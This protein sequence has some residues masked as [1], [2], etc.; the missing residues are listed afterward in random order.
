MRPLSLLS[1]PVHN[2]RVKRHWFRRVRSLQ[3]SHHWFH[4]VRSLRATDSARLK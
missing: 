1:L 4:P 2:P 3:V